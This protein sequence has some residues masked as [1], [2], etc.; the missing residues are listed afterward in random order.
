MAE[1]VLPHVRFHAHPHDMPPFDAYVITHKNEEVHSGHDEERIDD[2]GK[3]PVRNMVLE[4]SAG[5]VRKSDGNDCHHDSRS[6]VQDK[7][8]LVGLIIG[9]ETSDHGNKIAIFTVLGN[10]QELLS[11]LL[12]K[13]CVSRASFVAS[14]NI[15]L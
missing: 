15:W 7:E 4:K 6:H 9:K 14:F 5:D 2:H 8:G 12:K 13:I 3:I 1:K 10:M 11:K